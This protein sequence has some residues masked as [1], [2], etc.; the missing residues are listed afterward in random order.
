MN[1]N[2]VLAS[3]SPR[4]NQLLDMCGREVDVITADL[5]D[6]II[7]KEINSTYSG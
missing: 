1:K 4:R 2:I 7:Q 6:E 3:G 5:D